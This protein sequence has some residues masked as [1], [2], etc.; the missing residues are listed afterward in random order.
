MLGTGSGDA[1]S[2]EVA[3]IVV[4]TVPEVQVLSTSAAGAVGGTFSVSL[5]VDDSG[6]GSTPASVSASATET[7]MKAAIESLPGAG[8]V[9]VQRSANADAAFGFAW[10]ITFTS[11]CGDVSD[12]QVSADTPFGDRVL[13]LIVEPIGE[14]SGLVLPPTFYAALQERR[15]QHGLR[16]T[17][18]ETAT[19]GFRNGHGTCFYVDSTDLQPDQVLW[20]TGG[21]LG[22]VFCAE[23]TWVEKPLQLISTWD[24]DEL[25]MIRAAH[26]L[27]WGLRHRDQIAHVVAAG[28]LQVVDD[29]LGFDA[30]ELKFFQ[31]V[32]QLLGVADHAAEVLV[33]EGLTALEPVQVS[34]HGVDVAPVE[35]NL[36]GSTNFEFL[37]RLGG[38]VLL[39]ELVDVALVLV[40]VDCELRLERL[41]QLHG[42]D[43]VL[44]LALDPGDELACVVELLLAQ[45][46]DLLI[47]LVED[48]TAP[49]SIQKIW[50]K[51]L[52]AT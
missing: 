51:V 4:G 24:G 46:L 7:E 9:D 32:H 29:V 35:V 41:V 52:G 5:P 16:V 25:C 42:F 38:V 30:L 13:T 18:S 19:G 2:A 50:L 48:D 1:V 20:Y 6:F 49:N 22:V 44:L 40:L 37:R 23:T 45:F 8:S 26:H 14:R 31:L 3:D 21:Q 36:A 15:E 34:L 17:V 10:T 12:L 39:T 11:K 43:D 47:A 27:R 28:L 33:L